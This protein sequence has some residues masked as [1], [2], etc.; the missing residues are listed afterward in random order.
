MVKKYNL[1]W[2][3]KL[4]RTCLKTCIL[5]DRHQCGCTKTSGPLEVHGKMTFWLDPCKHIPAQF[6]GSVT[7][8]WSHWI[9]K[10]K[11]VCFINLGNTVFQNRGLSVVRNRTLIS[12]WDVTLQFA[13]CSSPGFKTGLQK[14]VWDITVA[15]SIF[16][17][18]CD[19]SKINWQVCVIMI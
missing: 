9:K 18:A 16:Y 11:F 8:F 15:T 5:S 17:T 3:I 4:M 2:K 12:K 19:V 7:H 1:N 10:K 13:K 14:P 6:M